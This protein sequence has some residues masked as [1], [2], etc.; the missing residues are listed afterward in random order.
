MEYNIKIKQYNLL[1]K[2]ENELYSGVINNLN[3]IT[4]FE[5]GSDVK[6]S[7]FFKENYLEI[8]RY[9]SPRSILHISNQASFVG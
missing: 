9:G 3:E 1:E 6:T 7:V 2:N 5:K 4:Y 8:V